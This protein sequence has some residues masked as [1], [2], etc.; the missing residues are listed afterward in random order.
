MRQIIITG[1]NGRL[2]LAMAR[3]FLELQDTGCVWLGIHS[4]S[5][6]VD[7]FLSEHPAWADR[8]RR[9]VLDV[10]SSENWRDAVDHIVQSAGRVD[11]LVNHAGFHQDCLLGQ[12]SDGAW[13]SVRSINLDGTF[14][15]CRAVLPAMIHQ[16]GG[17]IIN[18]A[19]LSALMAPA[20]QAHYA[21]AKAGVVAL[22]RSL[23]REVARLGITVNAVCPGYMDTESLEG[24][25]DA[26]RN[27]ALMR[28]P[29][30]RLGRPEELAA[31]VGFLASSSASYLT[32]ATLPL[33]G[34]IH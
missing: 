6:G 21:A 14:L 19:S 10:T 30:R 16:R 26:Q 33:D 5:D 13:E 7:R 32:G 11:V 24:W 9:V 8:V 4:R 3:H 23:A 25:T 20:G 28:I 22:S 27:A 2:A 29:M 17:R 34:G 31:L 15:G 12:M 18:I 1:G